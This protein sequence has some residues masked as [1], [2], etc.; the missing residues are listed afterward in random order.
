MKKYNVY[1]VPSGI[2]Y[3]GLSLIAAEDAIQ[4]NKFI[5]E[6]KESDP[7]NISSSWGYDYISENYKL[8]DIYSDKTGILYKGIYYSG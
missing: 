1:Q 7:K 3:R 6:F 5:K 8:D 2:Y 4:A